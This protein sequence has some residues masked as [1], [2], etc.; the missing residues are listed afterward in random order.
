MRSLAKV[1]TVLAMMSMTATAYAQTARSCVTDTEAQSLFA[2]L[3]PD[4]LTGVLKTCRPHLPAT[5]YMVVHG[6]DAV[7][8][9]QAAASGHW[10]TARAAFLKIA[11]AD[12]DDEAKVIA[13]MSD[14]ALRPF[15]GEA[16]AGT[17]AKDVKPADCPKID[18]FVA[19]L[20][21]IAPANVAELITSLVLL[22]GGK[23]KDD[24]KLC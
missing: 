22:A 6:E 24:L 3:M 1:G 15:V 2:Y 5:S 20:A 14:A 13:G 7:A 16:L 23:E 21:P 11:G 12:H 10:P 8:R 9:Y 18:R 17:V 19:A 4:A